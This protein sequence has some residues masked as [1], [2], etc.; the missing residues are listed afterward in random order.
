MRNLE[1][2]SM[3]GIGVGRNEAAVYEVWNLSQ[4]WIDGW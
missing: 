2:V 4:K 1:R 3:R